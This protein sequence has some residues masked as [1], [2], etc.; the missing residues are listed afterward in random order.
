MYR[1][2]HRVGD[3]DDLRVLCDD[4]YV[5]LFIEQCYGLAARN[6][7]FAYSFGAAVGFDVNDERTARERRDELVPLLRKLQH[8]TSLRSAERRSDDHASAVDVRRQARGTN[9]RSILRAGQTATGWSPCSKNSR[10]SRSIGE[11]KPLT[12]AIPASRMDRATS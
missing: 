4:R 5:R 12:M 7:C 3:L 9:I 6:E 10:H 8:W 2:S 11:W 1:E